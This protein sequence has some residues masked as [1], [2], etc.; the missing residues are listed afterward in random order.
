MLSLMF[1][2][3][4]TSILLRNDDKAASGGVNESVL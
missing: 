1:D 3:D 4:Q 2:I